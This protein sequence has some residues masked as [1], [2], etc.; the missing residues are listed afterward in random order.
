MD[1]LSLRL[2]VNIEA[3]KELN[4]QE[5]DPEYVEA[6]G[7]RS[8]RRAIRTVIAANRMARIGRGFAASAAGDGRPSPPRGGPDGE[9]KVD[10]TR[11]AT[12]PRLG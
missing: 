1:E 10:T 8:L 11:K 5:L 6:A 7:G 3:L 9:L 12:P 2:Q 4:A